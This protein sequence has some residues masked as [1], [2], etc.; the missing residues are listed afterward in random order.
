M[1]RVVVAL[2]LGLV[3]FVVAY[4]Q[5]RPTTA[6]T[7]SKAEQSAELILQQYLSEKKTKRCEVFKP[8]IELWRGDAMVFIEYSTL[9]RRLSQSL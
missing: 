1:K 9:M 7:E 3:S 4:E 8:V 2:S 6:L 5:G